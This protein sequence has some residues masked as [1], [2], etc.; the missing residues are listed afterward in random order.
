MQAQGAGSGARARGGAH[1]RCLTELDLSPGT[2]RSGFLGLRAVTQG[3]RRD[4]RRRNLP[5]GPI[6]PLGKD[7]LEGLNPRLLLAC[8]CLDTVASLGKPAETLGWQGSQG[9]GQGVDTSFLSV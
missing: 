8:V 3:V 2:L 7:L 1:R 9:Q 6:L 5:T 4:R